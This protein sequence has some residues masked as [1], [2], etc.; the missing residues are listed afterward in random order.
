MR[1]GIWV[2]AAVFLG[3]FGAHFLLQDRG[4]VLISFRSYVVE[5]SVPALVL[6]LALAY[7]LVRLALR[8]WRAPRQLGQSFAERRIRRSS[9]RL[10][11]GLIQMTEGDFSRGE[12]LLTQGIKGSDAPL[13]NYLMAARAA[14]SQGSVERRNEWLALAYDEL[15]EAEGA[16]LL[17]QAE[18]QL[19]AGDFAAT[20]ASVQKILDSRADHPVAL[21]LL[22]RSYSAL[23]DTHNLF[24]L[25]PRLARARLSAPMLENLACEALRGVLKR[26]D[27]GAEQLDRVWSAAP[28][29]VRNAAL[30]VALY[31]RALQAFEQGEQAE[32]MLRKALKRDWQA[33]LVEA[34]G[35]VAAADALKQLKQAELWLK[36]HS[37]DAALLLTAARLCMVNELWGKARSYLESSL[38][39]APGPE[40]YA[41]YGGLLERLGERDAAASAYQAGLRLAGGVDL[42]MPAL[43]APAR[44]TDA[45]ALGEAPAPDAA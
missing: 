29:A 25:L 22:A 2:L 36:E 10:T 15:P 13:V 20:R 1:L 40:A 7:A 21:A 28:P 16:I 26:G 35:Q 43:N 34:Y 45:P 19:E 30:P 6:L 18:L 39:L 9:D 17:T 23:G 8:L 11:R 14:Q 44:P 37:E 32:K 38:A 33:P 12:R 42:N 31:A 3:A 5:M 24:E 41:L 4:Y 27:I